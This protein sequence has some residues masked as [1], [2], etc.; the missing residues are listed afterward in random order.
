MANPVVTGLLGTTPMP[1]EALQQPN[2]T[3]YCGAAYVRNAALRVRPQGLT[4][5]KVTSFAPRAVQPAIVVY[6]AVASAWVQ[7]MLRAPAPH[8]A[9]PVIS[10][11]PPGPP[12]VVVTNQSVQVGQ[13]AFAARFLPFRPHI[14][15]PIIARGPPVRPAYIVSQAIQ[16]N[17][18]RRYRDVVAPPKTAPY[19][20]SVPPVFSTPIV[21]TNQAIQRALI[22][23]R[24][25][26]PH[27]PQLVGTTFIPSPAI[28]TEQ[29]QQARAIRAA[30]RGAVTQYSPIL[31]PPRRIPALIVSQAVQ[32]AYVGRQPLRPR[33]APALL[34]SPPPGATLR[35]QAVLGRPHIGRKVIP[36]HVASPIIGAPVP[37]I[38]ALASPFVA[39][40]LQWSN[41]LRSLPRTLV[42]PPVGPAPQ[43]AA[44]VVAN[45]VFSALPR[46]ASTRTPIPAHTADGIVIP[47]VRQGY[48]G[49][50]NYQAVERSYYSAFFRGAVGLAQFTPLPPGP[51]A[52]IVSQARQ[53]PF[54][55]RTVP[56]RPLV[57][58]P[59]I[60][61]AVPVHYGGVF[62]YQAVQT[63]AWIPRVRGKRILAPAINQ[64][65]GP[66]ITLV[67]QARPRTDER[68]YRDFVPAPHL[69][70]PIVP[71]FVAPVRPAI[72]V[73]QATR[74]PYVGR[75]TPAPHLAAPRVGV[76][77]RLAGITLVGQ[78]I[79]RPL[80]RRTVPAPRTAGPLL[81][82][83]ILVVLVVQ[84]GVIHPPDWPPS[85]RRPIPA[86]TTGPI[87]KVRPPVAPGTFVYQATERAT[88]GRNAASY[89][90]V[91]TPPVQP[92]FL[93][94]VVSQAKQRALVG[95]SVPLH[96]RIAGPAVSVRTP[97]RYVGTFTSQAS[98]TAIRAR[99][100]QP[101][102][103]LA[104]PLVGQVIPP[105]HATYVLASGYRG[106]IDRRGRV[107]LP[108][109]GAPPLP[110][111][112]V[113]HFQAVQRAQVGRGPNPK[114][115][116]PL[117]LVKPFL[118]V[119]GTFALQAV[120]RGQ[121]RRFR[122]VAPA[123][124][125]P[126]AVQTGPGPGATIKLQSQARALVR[127]EGRVRL[128]LPPPAARFAPAIVV[129][130]A[131]QR[132]YVGRTVP[133]PHRASPRDTK[134]RGA[135]II[136]QARQRPYVG[137]TV[138]LPHLPRPIVSSPPVP[139][140]VFVSAAQAR[141][142]QR[143]EGRVL[144]PKLA[145]GAPVPRG[146]FVSQAVQRPYIGRQA[147]YT[148]RARPIV[149]PPRAPIATRP[150][151]VLQ[152][153]QRA[154]LGRKIPP[155]PRYQ[156]IVFVPSYSATPPAV[157][158]TRKS[159]TTPLERSGTVNP[160][161]SRS[162]TTNPVE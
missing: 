89:L 55:G 122:D 51:G 39:S 136:I 160:R 13:H 158:I 15:A 145:A 130:Q 88:V 5:F 100:I 104:G 60:A 35:Y 101:K 155:P 115:H 30:S 97:V 126:P 116:L 128:P 11:V 90:S 14:A 139:R 19:P 144:L 159:V 81:Q 31:L 53:R 151:V 42:A 143:R 23:L 32:R 93:G 67:G 12:P 119:T 1:M 99:V 74:R 72:V 148:L 111:P 125:L 54:V 6:Q 108:T 3:F 58:G 127:R 18:E 150:R 71:P 156:P 95:R 103:K 86:H 102:P 96:P 137:R 33:I 61:H 20:L 26:A 46:A 161:P 152:A 22:G 92:L 120:A 80:T 8:L 57:A 141:Q 83:P 113:Y 77:P 66:G 157:V 28:V 38:A 21:I 73:G 94:L 110:A 62:V 10:L 36:P 17:Q 75:N 29:A 134:A 9:A 82:T 76:A 132:P 131:I 146:T 121:E 142:R 117:P 45:Q 37:K 85:L 47:P 149:T 50:L 154:L 124:H 153:I 2:T 114:P 68:R 64:P 65:M 27:L 133:K 34:A 63:A 162:G 70:P 79:Q 41:R 43:L 69:A 25:P 109:L 7:R 16:S 24:A 59:V 52:T 135:T 48:T 123:S 129:S 140:G 112:G 84:V 4:S 56:L 91:Q 106:L 78:A 147:A 105:G 44:V 98:Q 40:P 87:T 138:P 49:S 107:R 118:V